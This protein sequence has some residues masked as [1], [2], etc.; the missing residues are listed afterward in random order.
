[1]VR[2]VI[3]L[4]ESDKHWLDQ[5]AA[6]QKVSMAEVVRQAI[7]RLRAAR[8]QGG[9]DFDALLKSTSGRWSQGDGLAWQ[10]ARRQEWER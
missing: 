3:T 4:D 7:S 8:D 10:E 1:M 2:T 9:E 5:Q 6:L